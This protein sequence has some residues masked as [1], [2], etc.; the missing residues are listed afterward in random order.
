MISFY[1]CTVGSHQVIPTPPYVQ[2]RAD[3]ISTSPSSRGSTFAT[4]WPIIFDHFLE[5]WASEERHLTPLSDP[6]VRVI[7]TL[8]L[9]VAS[10]VSSPLVRQVLLQVWI[11]RTPCPCL[12]HL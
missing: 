6:M 1:G 4:F 3:Q 9:L 7:V 2:T 12:I 8:D 5:H 10:G 11:R